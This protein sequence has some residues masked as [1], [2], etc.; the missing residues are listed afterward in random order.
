MREE[1]EEIGELMVDD[2]GEGLLLIMF[3]SSL[4]KINRSL[5]G[6]VPCHALGALRNRASNLWGL[7]YL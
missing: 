7:N 4:N 5:A 2:E 3:S 1:E 6:A